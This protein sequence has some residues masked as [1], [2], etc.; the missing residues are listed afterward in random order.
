LA[1]GLSTL[2]ASP[3]AIPSPAPSLE[4]IA[5]NGAGLEKHLSSLNGR[6]GLLLVRPNQ[7][8]PIA[9][10]F[11]SDKAGT[12]LAAIPLDGGNVNGGNL[13]V[14]LTGKVLFTFSPGGAPG[15]CRVMVQTPLEQPLLEFYVVD[16]NHH[17]RQ[18]RH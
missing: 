9:L 17:P 14:L 3:P 4:V 10:Q 7:V 2:H 11:P 8:V 13:R 16:P 12:P 5:T 15:R 18:Q 6:V 1:V